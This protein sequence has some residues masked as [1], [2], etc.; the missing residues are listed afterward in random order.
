VVL[1]F[2]REGGASELLIREPS[3]ELLGQVGFKSRKS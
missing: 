1:A 2:I 3:I